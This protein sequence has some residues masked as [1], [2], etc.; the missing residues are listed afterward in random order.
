M[1]MPVSRRQF[2]KSACMTGISLSLASGLRPATVV[3]LCPQIFDWGVLENTKLWELVRSGTAPLWVA[4]KTLNS[5]AHHL[6]FINLP[7]DLTISLQK[8]GGEWKSLLQAKG[9]WETIP[10]QIRAGGRSEI[11]RF[12]AG[13]D[14]SHRIP[15]SQGGPTTPDNGIFELKLL[16]R[17]RGARTMT[18]GEIAAARAVIRSDVVVSVIRQTLG[19]A[20]KGAIIGVIVSGILTSLECGLQYADKKITW[21]EMVTKIKKGILF[22]GG[23]SFLITGLLV[24][25]GLIFPG[26]IPLLV[27]PMFVIRIVG[28]VFLAQNAVSLGKRYWELIEEHGLIFEA[29]QVLREAEEKLRETVDELKQSIADRIREWLRSIAIRILWKRAVP[30]TVGFREISGADRVPVWLATQTQLVSRYAADTVSPLKIRG[31]ADERHNILLSLDL[32]E[33]N[34]P[35]IIA[36]MEE[37]KELIARTIHCEFTKAICTAVELREYLRA[38]LEGTDWKPSTVTRGVFQPLDERC[39]RFPLVIR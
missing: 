22:A 38:C 7:S 8:A 27:V 14:W 30:S 21:K 11:L 3:Q 28:L 19:A 4:G 39:N 10:P 26:L 20:A 37:L 34:L 31:Y 1:P 15:R 6:R 23:L 18:S 25:L 12:L 2:L 17:M 9:L 5:F 32:P 29:C 24:G 13:K 33:L 36:S 35:E 16:N